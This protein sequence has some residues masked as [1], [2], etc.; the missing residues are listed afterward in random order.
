MIFPIR[1]RVFMSVR[2]LMHYSIHLVHTNINTST[3]LFERQQSMHEDEQLAQKPGQSVV[4]PILLRTNSEWPYRSS[5]ENTLLNTIT[6]LLQEY[7]LHT[8][9][10]VWCAPSLWRSVT[11]LMIA[12]Q[13]Q[14]RLSLRF[15][16][17][18]CAVITYSH[19]SNSAGSELMSHWLLCAFH[20]L[21]VLASQ[22]DCVDS[23]FKWHE[24][25]WENHI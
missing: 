18:K 3:S 2:S 22:L 11:C 17:G 9:C 21:P 19:P 4:A 16:Y 20:S 6:Y 8:S 5:S 7:R 13:S 23:K 1:C 12:V 14:G 15:I 25:P 10:L 24:H